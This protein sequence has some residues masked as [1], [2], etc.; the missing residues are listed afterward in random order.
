[1]LSRSIKRCTAYDE[2]LASGLK[3]TLCNNYETCTCQMDLGQVND[4]PSTSN[5][6][7]NAFQRLHQQGLA[8]PTLQRLAAVTA[9]ASGCGLTFSPPPK[10]SAGVHSQ[11]NTL[12]C[13][14]LPSSA[15]ILKATGSQQMC[16]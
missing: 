4:V 1:M 2:Q 11:A 10:V 3:M 13:T 5:M 9:A 6:P 14:L 8:D 12:N 7:V 16:K 15:C